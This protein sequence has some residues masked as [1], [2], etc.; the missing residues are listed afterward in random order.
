MDRETRLN[1]DS[2]VMEKV[3]SYIGQRICNLL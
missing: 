2:S 1:F 3:L